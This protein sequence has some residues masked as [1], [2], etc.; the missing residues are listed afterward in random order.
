MHKIKVAKLY[1]RPRFRVRTDTDPSFVAPSFIPG[2]QEN[3]IGASVARGST[4]QPGIRQID[5]GS[6]DRRDS[7][8]ISCLSEMYVVARDD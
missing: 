3:P 2:S 4:M 7:A 5:S 6:A 1:N 8:A